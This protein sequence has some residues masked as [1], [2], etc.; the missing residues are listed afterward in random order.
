MVGQILSSYLNGRMFYIGR[1]ISDSDLYPL[2]SYTFHLPPSLHIYIYCLLYLLFITPPVV[3]YLIWIYF[4]LILGTYFKYIQGRKP[5]SKRCFFSLLKWILFCMGNCLRNPLSTI[6]WTFNGKV[7]P[8]SWSNFRLQKWKMANNKRH[9]TINN[10][11]L[12]RLLWFWGL[13][14]FACSVLR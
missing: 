1:Y 3:D 13:S 14:I 9:S 6:N 11:R 2:T 5:I 8:G 4:T 12:R 10:I 7:N